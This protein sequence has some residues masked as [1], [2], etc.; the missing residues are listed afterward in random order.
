MFTSWS[1]VS[2]PGGV[3]DE[4][5]VDGAAVTVAAGLGVLDP[6]ALG[7]PEVA[8]LADT[9]GP[10]LATVDPDRV[11]GLVAGVGMGLVGGLHVGADAAVPE[12]V[13]RRLQDRLH[14]LGRS[15]RRDRRLE[16]EGLAHL[17]ADRDG[18]QRPGP[19]ATA[20]GDQRLVVVLPARPRQPEHPLALGERRGRIGVGVDEDVAVVERRDQPGVLGAQQSVAEDVAGHV[21]DAHAGEVLRLAVEAALAEVALHGDPG[22]ASGD[23]HRLVVVADRAAGG[24][25]VAEPEPVVLGDAV[26]DVGERRGALVR[27]DHEV[28]VVASRG[29]RRRAAPPSRRRRG[30]R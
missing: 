22:S 21:A 3:V 24:E 2:T 20:L 27:G 5:G 9:P 15:H 26:G 6:A 12:Q 8:A 11:V 23:P 4:V 13:D 28:G 7:E 18:L 16:T 17:G 14:Q 29:V 30:C 1:E 19:D 25:G 10:H